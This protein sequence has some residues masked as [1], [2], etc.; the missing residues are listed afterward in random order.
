MKKIIINLGCG[1]AIILLKIFYFFIKL[2]TKQK[3]KITM[4]SRQ[5][6]YISLDFELIQKELEKKH[7]NIQIVILCKKIPKTFWKRIG[8]CFYMI[9]M[10]YH[11][12][13]A[14]ACIIDGYIIP[15]SVLNHKK[16][17]KI[18]QIWHAMGAIKKFG[19][20]IIE[21]AEGSKGELASS[22]KMHRNYTNII[23][24]SKA[25]KKFYEQAFQIENE[26]ILVLGMPKIDYL[27]GK[28][29]LIQEKANEIY[30][31]YSYLKEKKTILYVPTFRKN[32]T[33]SV[34]KLIQETEKKGY[35]LIIRLHPLDNT[36][37]NK[38]YKIADN[39]KTIDLLK[40]AD[41]IITDYS[42]IAFDAC[43]LNKPVLFYLYDIEKYQKNRG[44]NVDLQK[45]MP[46]STFIHAEDMIQVIEK[47]TYQYEELNKFRK[48]YIE[49][50]DTKN[51]QRIVEY[52]MNI[53]KK[54][55]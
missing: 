54:E 1:I 2:V 42:A 21:K 3:E 33:V 17:L 32:Q 26:K 19:W 31:E 37:I 53:I 49:T 45:E 41:Y 24:T 12:A 4:L 51:T 14:K 27:L 10:L 11:I 22:M 18:I 28:D 52:V 7:P 40:I 6:D 9:K 46:F 23:C 13:T 29:G 35:N 38:K 8:Y 43:V 20:Q 48:K 36:P 47:E 5:S 16:S 15:I 50:L 34:E 44:L 25:T 39:Y 55:G 30:R